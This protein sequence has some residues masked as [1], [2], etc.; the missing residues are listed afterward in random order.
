[1]EKTIK[2][3]EN[4]FTFV[5]DEKANKILSYDLTHKADWSEGSLESMGLRI[6]DNIHGLETYESMEDL[7]SSIKKVTECVKWYACKEVKSGYVWFESG[8]GMWNDSK[9]YSAR[10]QSRPT[11]KSIAFEWAKA[12]NFSTRFA[13][14]IGGPK[15]LGSLDGRS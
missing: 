15:D 3:S 5:V 6:A 12:Q 4:G 9:S 7:R 13:S 14:M 2:L 10:A 11:G 8:I 1:M